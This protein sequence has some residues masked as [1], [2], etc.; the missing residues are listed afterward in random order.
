[1]VA[2]YTI[3]HSA[4]FSQLVA[5]QSEQAQIESGSELVTSDRD[6]NPSGLRW[7]HPLPRAGVAGLDRARLVAQGRS[8]R[9]VRPWSIVIVSRPIG[10][11]PPGPRWERRS[12]SWKCP[13]DFLVRRP[14]AA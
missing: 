2:S 14:R 10:K 9:I 4:E 7:R 5:A 13:R 3:K 12:T 11:Q 6:F 1:V 8:I